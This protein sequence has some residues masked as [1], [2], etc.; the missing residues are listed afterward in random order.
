MRPRGERAASDI[1]ENCKVF[2]AAIEEKDRQDVCVI[3][4]R[5]KVDAVELSER[6]G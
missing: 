3:H 2:P 1:P 4:V 6:A 5:F